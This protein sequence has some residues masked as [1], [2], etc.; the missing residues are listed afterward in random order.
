MLAGFTRALV[1]VALAALLGGIECD[2]SCAAADCGVEQA[3]SSDCP[4]HAPARA[5]CLHQHTGFIAPEAAVLKHTLAQTDALPLPLIYRATVSQPPA[6]V[7]AFDT[8]SPPSLFI[9]RI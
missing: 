7:L 6:L 1:F 3:P 5:R 9:L 4:H 8:G 2:A